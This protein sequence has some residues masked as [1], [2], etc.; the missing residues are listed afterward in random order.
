MAAKKKE[1]KTGDIVYIRAQ[2][3][4]KSAIEGEEEYYELVLPASLE[5]RFA[6]ASMPMATI[7][8]D[9]IKF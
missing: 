9:D 5:Y 4:Q 7:H 8:K 6:E 3:V 1:P 2:M